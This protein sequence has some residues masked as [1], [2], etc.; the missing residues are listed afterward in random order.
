MASSGLERLLKDTPR[1]TF[2]VKT[3]TWLAEYLQRVE[4]GQKALLAAWHDRTAQVTDKASLGKRRISIDV[5]A[6]RDGGVECTTDAADRL[7]S[8]ANGAID[9]DPSRWC[10][11]EPLFQ[12]ALEIREAILEPRDAKVGHALYSLGVCVR[13]AAGRGEEAK[14]LLRRAV[15]IRDAKFGP[16]D[17]RVANALHELGMCMLE[18]GQIKQASNVFARAFSIREAKLGRNDIHV[19][20]TLHELG[21]CARAAGRHTEAV[22]LLMRALKITSAKLGSDHPRVAYTLHDLSVCLRQVGRVEEAEHRLRRALEIRK[23][24]LGAKDVQVRH[25][26]GREGAAGISMGSWRGEG[27]VHR[28]V[29]LGATDVTVCRYVLRD[30]RL[31]CCTESLGK[32]GAASKGVYLYLPLYLGPNGS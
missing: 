27:C 10:E 23:A 16:Y 28:D 18:D 22:A 1:D 25:T 5:T 31:S 15:E 13:Q 2:L 17:V 9:A 4:N 7:F 30:R 6:I 8:L 26:A 29:S 20:H 21:V 14:W 12:R 24:K 19:A 3:I 32:A 11:V